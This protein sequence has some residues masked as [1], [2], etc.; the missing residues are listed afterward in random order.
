MA[1]SRHLWAAGE[2][3]YRRILTHPFLKGLAD[4]TLP[5]DAFRHYVI[6]DA[7][8][9]RD[10]GRGL[11]LLGARAERS[12]DLELF[13]NHAANAVAVERELHEGF[14]S[15]WGLTPEEVMAT[16]PAPNCLLYTSYLMRVALERPYAEGLAAFLPC[17][18][19]YGEVG[20]ELAKAGSPDPLY[21]RWIE[22]YGGEAFDA[23]VR[24]VVAVVDR[25][26][27][28]ADPATRAAM[29]LHYVRGVRM[30]YLFWDMGWSGQTWPV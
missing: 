5:K 22:T 21:R 1:F 6:Q 12:E 7:L 20:K 13:C 25:A 3:V 2:P 30:E 14:F 26:G 15:G 23:V 18:W 29:E 17:Y 28:A 4:G 8:Y 24:A 27:A 19:I 11:A 16:E 10:F 9:L